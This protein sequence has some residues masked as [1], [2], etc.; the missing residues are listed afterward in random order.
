MSFSFLFRKNV[1]KV[2]LFVLKTQMIFMFFMSDGFALKYPFFLWV[3]PFIDSDR[4]QSVQILIFVLANF[5][6]VDSIRV[7]VKVLLWAN[8]HSMM[9]LKFNFMTV[10]NFLLKTQTSKDLNEV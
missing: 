10:F 6:F 3:R 9:F 7:F 2:D 8:H 4:S 1:I 5:S